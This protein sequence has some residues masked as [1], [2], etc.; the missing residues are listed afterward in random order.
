MYRHE[1]MRIN[2]TTYDLRRCQDVLN[3][4]TEH[5]NIMVN[6]QDDPQ[7]RHYHPYW[8]G[9]V[10]GIFHVNVSYINDNGM[11]DEPRLI[12]FLFVRWFGLDSTYRAGIKNKRLNR[13]GF[14]LAGTDNTE[15]FGFVDPANVIRGIHLIPEFNTAPSQT[16][17]TV[18]TTGQMEDGDPNSSFKVLLGYSNSG[19]SA[20][21]N[22]FPEYQFYY[23]NQYVRP[24]FY[25]SPSRSF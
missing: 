22:F 9:N 19:D 10:I 6:A 23:V 15:A 17:H 25:L 14:I 5:C 1:T 4:K 8:Y 20:S 7:G 11:A 16:C 24:F 13:I 18:T 2:F 3:P 21:D 12:H